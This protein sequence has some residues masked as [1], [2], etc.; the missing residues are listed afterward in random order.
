MLWI[1]E[2]RL[3]NM[4]NLVSIKNLTINFRENQNVVDSVNINIPKGK[5]VAIVGESGSGKTL[6]AL[7]ILKLLP[8][9]AIIKN[10]SIIF[11]LS[12]I[13]I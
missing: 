4:N 9:S 10:G 6:S 12:L 11:N 8:T 3:I 1:Q 2:R 13:H 5:T 7:S